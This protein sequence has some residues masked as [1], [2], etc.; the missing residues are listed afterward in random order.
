MKKR[1]IF[2][3]ALALAGLLF[4]AACEQ[5]AGTGAKVK[6]TLRDAAA[7]ARIGA[8]SDYPLDGEYTLGADLTLENWKPIGTA[9]APFTG[10]FNG[11]GKTLAIVDGSGGL[12]GFTEGA[13]VSNVTVTGTI[14]AEGGVVYAGGIV[15]RGIDTSIVSCTSS[16]DIAVAA[17]GH[18]SSA[19]GIAAY[20]SGVCRVVDCHATGN[21]TLRSEPD[22]GL[23][24]YGGGVAGY[25]GLIGAFGGG[26]DE[27]SH[28][29]ME[30][31][32]FTGGAVVV[33]GGYPYAGGLVG[34]N[35]TGAVLRE[36]YAAGGTVTAKGENLPYAGGVAGY[37]SR[38]E[39]EPSLIE[40]CYGD[41]TVNGVAVSRQALAGGVAGSNAA[42]AKISKCYARG[43]VAAVV[44]GGSGETGGTLG[45]LAAANAGGIAGSQY[46]GMPSIENCA[47]LNTE[48]AG[49][50]GV[51][52]VRRI[53]GEGSD[54]TGAW[55]ENIASAPLYHDGQ[56][57][58]PS[59]VNAA[60]FDGADCDAQPD[61]S[62]YEALG[63][64]FAL[65]WKMGAEG[66]PVLQWQP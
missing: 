50:G 45:V 3:T 35:Y 16:V 62:A 63:W 17:E 60:G 47:A 64:D 32:S 8:N 4:A 26:P 56:A 59:A 65:V 1:S 61:Q 43:S 58:E 57:V 55:T 31:C 21:I 22:R 28:C 44:S 36:S 2:R 14:N 27:V 9:S 29:L 51:Y 15:G 25:Q 12:F 48:I 10:T 40:N 49:R 46:V 53:A 41:M 33:E 66:Y 39:T 42:W 7:L 19:G 52:N 11:S 54:E 24:L 37:N 30:R 18:N 38:G 13:A 23:M 5:P 6:E 20:L 34:Y